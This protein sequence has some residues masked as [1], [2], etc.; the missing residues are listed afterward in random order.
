[1]AEQ[2]GIP[3]AIYDVFK[4]NLTAAFYSFFLPAKNITG[5]A[6]RFY[7]LSKVNNKKAEALA[8]I[9]FDR[10]FATI[11]LCLV[12]A[13]F[14]SMDRSYTAGNLSYSF[15]IIFGILLIVTILLSNVRIPNFFLKFFE[16][17][18]LSSFNT[19]L[20]KFYESLHK[21]RT[22][23]IKSRAFILILSVFLHLL[24][25]LVYFLLAKSLGLNISVVTIG[26]VRAA[27]IL[28][29]MVPV[30]ISGLGIREGVLIFL[31][32]PYGVAGEEAFALSILIFFATIL[33][34]GIIGG[35]YEISKSVLRVAR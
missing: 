21:Y 6:I 20:V 11:A 12:G 24:D 18:H 22:V 1:L 33:M 26:W 28:A 14:W 5:G 9:I 30:T 27:T 35:L 16:S 17:L 32:S 13:L 7:G 31:L 4:I 3:I 15:I 8:S 10:V 2:Q 34:V 29:T 23:P 25:V 19:S